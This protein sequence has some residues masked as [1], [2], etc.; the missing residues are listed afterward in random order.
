MILLKGTQILN[1]KNVDLA[2]QFRTF[3]IKISKIFIYSCP[4]MLDRPVKLNKPNLPN[5]TVKKS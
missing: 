3:Q 5:L 2:Y 4:K 1:S